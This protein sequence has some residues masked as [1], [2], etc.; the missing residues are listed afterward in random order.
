MT[1]IFKRIRE[2]KM[3][4][5]LGWDQIAAEAGIPLASW[6]TGIPTSVPSDAD[7]KKLAP[8]LK[9]T[10]EWLKHGKK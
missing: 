3:K 7:L 2:L 4:L 9:T 10:F 8:V 5:G 1:P 6:M